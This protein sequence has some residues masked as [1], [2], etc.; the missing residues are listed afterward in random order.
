[1][2]NLCID[3]IYHFEAYPF[4]FEHKNKMVQLVLIWILN[5]DK[6]IRVGSTL[7]RNIVSAVSN[8]SMKSCRIA[9]QTAADPYI[10]NVENGRTANRRVYNF[11][12]CIVLQ[13]RGFRSNPSTA[14]ASRMII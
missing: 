8:Y 5:L 12:Y 9:L 4:R 3:I 10:C 11:N 14:P 2:R 6:D 1:M 7:P 13:F